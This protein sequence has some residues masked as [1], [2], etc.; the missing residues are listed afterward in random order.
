M[1]TWYSY[2]NKGV[3]EQAKYSKVIAQSQFLLNYLFFHYHLLFVFHWKIQSVSQMSWAVYLISYCGFIMY[4]SRY[5]KIII[6]HSGFN[7]FHYRT[8]NFLIIKRRVCKYNIFSLRDICANH[9]LW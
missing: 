5:S 7:G 1:S 4:I 8:T 2:D 3:T 6:L 9:L